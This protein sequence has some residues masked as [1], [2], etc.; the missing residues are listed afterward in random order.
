MNLPSF[1]GFLEH[2]LFDVSSQFFTMPV[3]RR[4]SS[5][6][7][8][9]K[10]FD[11]ISS[12]TSDDDQV[13]YPS[14]CT[15]VNSLLICRFS[16]ILDSLEVEF[17]FSIEQ[18]AFSSRGLT[19]FFATSSV[20]VFVF[21]TTGGVVRVR[22]FI[23]DGLEGVLF[24]LFTV[25]IERDRNF[26]EGLGTAD[27][28]A[29]VGGRIVFL[30]GVLFTD[31]TARVDVIVESFLAFA[32]TGV[33]TLDFFTGVICLADGIVVRMGNF[34]AFL[35]DNERWWLLLLSSSSLLLVDGGVFELEVL[36]RLLVRLLE[37]REGRRDGRR[38]GGAGAVIARVVGQRWT[39]EFTVR[40]LAVMLCLSEEE[41]AEGAS[42]GSLEM[43]NVSD[44]WRTCCGSSSFRA[45][46][47]SMEGDKKTEGQF[48][49]S[50]YLT[51]WFV[52]SRKYVRLNFSIL[53]VECLE[54]IAIVCQSSEMEEWGNSSCFPTRW[55]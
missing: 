32:A 27:D 23:T 44:R 43:T 54:R 15:T 47:E 16:S 17:I 13:E 46:F 1:T 42:C 39:F 4:R 3:F 30:V 18:V 34:E 8:F 24:W 53:I 25:V 37:Q 35:V 38:T 19:N 7:F 2:R 12:L 26:E 21:F 49:R 48:G 10:L 50:S 51:S 33:R 52:G 28:L 5:V 11:W 29:I 9:F 22:L 40:S 41:E 20:S 31:V 45:D 55:L 14:S 6:A 36:G